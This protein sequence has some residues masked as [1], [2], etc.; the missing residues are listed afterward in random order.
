MGFRGTSLKIAGVWD[1]SVGIW[2]VGMK[3]LQLRSCSWGSPLLPTLEKYS[4]ENPWNSLFPPRP[5]PPDFHIKASK[6][7]WELRWLRSCSHPNKNPGRFS[8]SPWKIR[9][10]GP[11]GWAGTTP[12]QGEL[13]L[14]LVPRNSR[15]KNSWNPILPAIPI[16]GGVQEI[17]GSGAR[18]SG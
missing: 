2:D 18:G 11:S 8:P 7:S 4:L 15:S 6:D 17:P 16:P 14:I 13:K 3:R 5:F 10:F 1:G 9:D 12:G